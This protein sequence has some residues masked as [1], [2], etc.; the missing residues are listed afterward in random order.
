[1]GY[2][3]RSTGDTSRK[4]NLRTA[5]TSGS[6]STVAWLGAMG[7]KRQSQYFTS[8]AATFLAIVS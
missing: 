1:V 2:E 7:I 5:K 6:L 8:S 3:G 4:G